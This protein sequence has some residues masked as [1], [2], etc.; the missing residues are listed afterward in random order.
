VRQRLNGLINAFVGSGARTGTMGAPTA[1]MRQALEEAKIDF[2]AIE[3][4][5]K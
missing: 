1:T 5:I 3:G 4:E 2:A